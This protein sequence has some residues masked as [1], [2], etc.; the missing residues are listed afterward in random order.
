MKNK[1]WHWQGGR[2]VSDDGHSNLSI[3]TAYHFMPLNEGIADACK[4]VLETYNR[5]HDGFDK[6]LTYMMD[7]PDFIKKALGLIT[8]T[9]IKYG[10]WIKKEFNGF[11]ETIPIFDD[12][13]I[14]LRYDG[15]TFAMDT[16]DAYHTYKIVVSSAGAISVYIDS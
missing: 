13:V 8:D 9:C 7:D 14:T 5:E 4:G 11:T 1:L 6:L 15:T 16:T 12:D 3:A 2:L 10:M